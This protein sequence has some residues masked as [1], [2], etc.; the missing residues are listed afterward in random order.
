MAGEDTTD[1]KTKVLSLQGRA[2]EEI[3]LKHP[4]SC[5]NES[6]EDIN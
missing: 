3:A 5:I 2:V 6:R 1:A 4:Q